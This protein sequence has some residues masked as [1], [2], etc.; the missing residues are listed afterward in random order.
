MEH[1]KQEVADL[2]VRIKALSDANTSPTREFELGTCVSA[3]TKL[4]TL[5]FAAVTDAKLWAAMV[6]PE[7]ELHL[8]AGMLPG[9]DLLS[10]PPTGTLRKDGLRAIHGITQVMQDA[11]HRSE[12]HTSELQSLL[13][14]SYAVFCLKKKT[15]TSK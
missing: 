8:P 3:V 11:A 4:M 9:L 5:R 13:R 10:G 7:F 2:V 12:E 15:K 14:S 1:V 6:T